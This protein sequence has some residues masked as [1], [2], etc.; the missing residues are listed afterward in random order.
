MKHPS[1][2]A[3]DRFDN[4][5]VWI[6]A[7]MMAALVG[8]VMCR[9][10]QADEHQWYDDVLFEV[11]L[12][13]T[14]PLDG[15]VEE[16]RNFQF[17]GGYQT[18]Y[19]TWEVVDEWEHFI[20]G[21]SVMETDVS[22]FGVGIRYP[23]EQFEVYIETGVADLDTQYNEPAGSEVAYTYLVGRHDVGDRRIPVPCAYGSDCYSSEW[24]IESDSPFGTVGVAW[25]PVDHLKVQ[26][27]Y[28]YLRPEFDVE[29]KRPDFDAS[30]NPGYWR[31]TGRMDMD[32]FKLTV[33]LFW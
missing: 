22:Q 2:R 16:A 9:S 5:F 28:T 13:Y 12:G 20:L 18:V 25:A 21:Q 26:A 11:G 10:A 17:R 6:V 15:D 33:L 7:A 1:R 14:F 23:I 3:S 19:A 31:E 24:N 27:S 29:I 30:V 4:A 8:T 32:S